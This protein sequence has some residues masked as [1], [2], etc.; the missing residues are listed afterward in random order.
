MTSLSGGSSVRAVQGHCSVCQDHQASAFQQTCAADF[1]NSTEDV[2][3]YLGA[4]V[5]TLLCE[6]LQLVGGAVSMSHRK[7]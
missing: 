6:S 2:H 4:L 5:C 3:M 7:Q 1:T